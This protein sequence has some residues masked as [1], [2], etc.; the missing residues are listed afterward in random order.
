[1]DSKYSSYHLLYWALNLKE[2]RTKEIEL[3]LWVEPNEIKHWWTTA[4]QIPLN[5]NQIHLWRSQTRPWKPTPS[6]Y[7]C[8]TWYVVDISLS[9]ILCDGIF[10][11]TS[12]GDISNVCLLIFRT[13]DLC[14]ATTPS[15]RGR[16]LQDVASHLLWYMFRSCNHIFGVIIPACGLDCLEIESIHLLK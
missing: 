11:D 16:Q 7:N 2:S 9:E 1:M 13:S 15:R 8:S 6:S 10:V 14:E 5:R 4:C 12:T 3:T